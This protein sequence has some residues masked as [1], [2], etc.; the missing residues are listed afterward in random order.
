MSRGSLAAFLLFLPVMTSVVA[1]DRAA[2]PVK[3]SR[4]Y[5]SVSFLGVGFTC[6]A[7][8]CIE[9]RSA[10]QDPV[11]PYTS[12]EWAALGALLLSVVVTLLLYGAT[13]LPGARPNRDEVHVSPSV[14]KAMLARERVRE[15]TTLDKREK[16]LQREKMESRNGPAE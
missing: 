1:N 3:T 4:N 5:I 15:M 11:Q 13:R 6:L 8:G 10:I 2:M 7:L 16:A 9:L 12:V 14:G